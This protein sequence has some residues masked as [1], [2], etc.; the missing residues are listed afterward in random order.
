M[1]WFYFHCAERLVL[2]IETTTQSEV[3]F[4][5]V[6]YRSFGMVPTGPTFVH[7]HMRLE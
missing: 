3:Y 5:V 2:C 4:I 7:G 1:L 6:R